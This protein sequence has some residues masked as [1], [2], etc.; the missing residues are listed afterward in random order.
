M[1][2][3]SDF[4]TKNSKIAEN[5]IKTK[6]ITSVSSKVFSNHRL[7]DRQTNRRTAK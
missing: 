7:K 3:I 5:E 2:F 4:I 6:T 1:I